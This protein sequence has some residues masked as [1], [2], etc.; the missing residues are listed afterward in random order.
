LKA[1][2]AFRGE[3]KKTNL[4]SSERGEIRTEKKKFG[5]RGK[6]SARDQ[7]TP[8]PGPAEG[9]FAKRKGSAWG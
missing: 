5:G 4:T 2:G 9:N 1:R 7:K 6:G 8:T 3:G